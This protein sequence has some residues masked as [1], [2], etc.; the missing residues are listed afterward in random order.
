MQGW[1][2]FSR[3]WR[4]RG[5]SHGPPQAGGDTGVLGQAVRVVSASRLCGRGAGSVGFRVVRADQ[6]LVC[7]LPYKGVEGTGGVEMYSRAPA[8]LPHTHQP[9]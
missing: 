2:V 5:S 1:L 8:P 7:V 9:A 4:A 6:G 3:T